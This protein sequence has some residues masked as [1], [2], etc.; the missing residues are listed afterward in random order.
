MVL[1][2]T[3]STFTGNRPSFMKLIEEKRKTFQIF[4]SQ[5]GMMQVEETQPLT[6]EVT[7]VY[8]KKE[9]AELERM[10]ASIK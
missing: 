8:S 2:K 6:E 7:V 9:E 10:F 3:E 1:I 4:V 5:K